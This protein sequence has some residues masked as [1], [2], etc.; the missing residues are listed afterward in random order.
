M[1]LFIWKVRYMICFCQH[2]GW[3]CIGLGWDSAD[4]WAN[5]FDWREWH[6]VDACLEELSNW[7]D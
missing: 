7:G 3:T 1:K 5:D 6:P 2:V 4:N